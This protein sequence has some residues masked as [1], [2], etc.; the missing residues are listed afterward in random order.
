MLM[1][2]QQFA[3]VSNHVVTPRGTHR[4]AVVVAQGKI[5]DVCDPAKVPS[6]IPVHD[7]GDLVVAPGII[8]SHIHIN[9]PG[10]SNW[11]GFETGTQAAAAGGITTLI[12]MPLNSDPVTIDAD[13]LQLKREAA[14]GKCWVDVGFY[15]GLVPS[16]VDH[17]EQL[18]EQGVF[19]IKAF[20]CDSGL[21]EFPATP[22]NVLA[23]ALPIIAASGLPLLV[24]AELTDD[25]A[26]TMHDPRSFQQ[27]VA[28]RPSTWELAAIQML[29]ELVERSRAHVHIVHLANADSDVLTLLRNARASGLP[30]SVETCPH[31]LYF[32][33]EEIPDGDP[34]YKCAPPIR[35]RSN[36]EQLRA[37]LLNKTIDTIGSD[38]SPCPADMKFLEQGDVRSAWGGISGVQFT[39]PAVWT[40]MR[41]YQVPMDKLFE[42]LAVEPA[43]L[44]GLERQK[45]SIAVGLDADL[46]IWDPEAEWTVRNSDIVHRNGISPY[47][48]QTL[49]GKVLSTYVRGQAVYANGQHSRLSMGKLIRP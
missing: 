36:R 15:G 8:D 30:I 3:I 39:L 12:D 28:S 29:I 44:L 6:E 2:N 7:V 37:A 4:W 33:G 10:R 9:E 49:R 34:R 17:L 38:H 16:N 45:G 31:Y 14:Q 5:V 19:G 43:R 26:P 25:K 42:W 32:C 20:L 13:S 47:A 24:H 11:E 48:G 18:I 21:P 1:E 41:P 27:F 23:T 35:S 46:I 40:A 22:R